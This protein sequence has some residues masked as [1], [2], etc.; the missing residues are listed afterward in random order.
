MLKIAI[1]GS[2]GLIGSRIQELLYHD[3]IFLPI[4]QSKVD[5]A[6]R[7]SVEEFCTQNE[8]HLMLHLAAYTPVDQAEKDRELAMKVNKEGTQN[9]FEAVRKKRKKFIYI[10]TDFVFDGENPPYDE[11][12]KPNPKGVYGK[13]KYEGE[14]IVGKDGMIVRISYPYRA[15]FDKKKDLVRS[16]Q[17]YLTEGKTLTMIGDTN[18]TPTFIDDIAYALKHLFTH[19]S[20]G[21]YHIVGSESLSPYEVGIAIADTFDLDASLIKKT[22]YDEFYKD[23]DIRPK[24][25]VIKSKKNTFWKMKSFH[26]GLEEIKR[27]QNSPRE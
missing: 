27:Q 3:F 1:S 5:I 23:N 8:F 14:K 7:K 19:Y 6:D 12:S 22:T 15:E 16:I 21:I 26:E 11:D 25:S 10:S 24:Q 20:S 13:T 17:S 2:T 18:I 4:L 9:L